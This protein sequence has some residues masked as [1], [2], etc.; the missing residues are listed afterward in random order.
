MPIC[1]IFWRAISGS[2]PKVDPS[3]ISPL[4]RSIVFVAVTPKLPAPTNESAL[5]N[6]AL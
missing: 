5:P 2:V 1:A 3:T 6:R 4:P